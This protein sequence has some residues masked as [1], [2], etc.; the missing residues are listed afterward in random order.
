[1]RFLHTAFAIP[2]LDDDGHMHSCEY[3]FFGIFFRH[4]NFNHATFDNRIFICT[5]SAVSGTGGMIATK[6]LLLTQLELSTDATAQMTIADV[7]VM[8]FSILTALIIRNYD[9]LDFSHKINL[10]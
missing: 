1:M 3:I 5:I 8:N 4:A 9:L 7:F 6:T 10:K 2:L